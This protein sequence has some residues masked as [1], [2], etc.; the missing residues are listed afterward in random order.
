MSRRILSDFP[1]GFFRSDL[2][3]LVFAR[4]AQ[5]FEGGA[6]WDPREEEKPTTETTVNRKDTKERKKETRERKRENDRSPLL[7]GSK[8]WT[9]GHSEQGESFFGAAAWEEEI[10]GQLRA[11]SR[12]S[13]ER[14]RERDEESTAGGRGEKRHG[15]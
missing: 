4:Q 3:F 9:G 11:R 12:V 10:Q 13:G 15:P 1:I 5:K 8:E 2:T 14:E 6:A 7:H